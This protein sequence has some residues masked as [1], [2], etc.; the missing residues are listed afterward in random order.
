MTPLQEAIKS[1]GFEW[2]CKIFSLK[3]YVCDEFPELIGVYYS[4]VES[5]LNDFVVRWARGTVLERDTWKLVA[6]SFPRFAAYGKDPLFESKF[7]WSTA[8]CNVK[9]DGS[10][11]MLFWWKDRWIVKNSHAFNAKTQNGTAFSDLFWENYYRFNNLGDLDK[12]LT[13]LF[14]I[15]SL[16][17]KVVRVYPQPKL[18]FLGAFN[19][20]YE[21]TYPQVKTLLNVPMPDTHQFKSCEQVLAMLKIQ[22]VNDPTFEGYVCRDS[23]N[24]RIKFK[25]DS[26]YALHHLFDNG[27]IFLKK[28][29]VK[30]ICNY[31]DKDKILTD[32][33]D[34]RERY[35]EVEGKVYDV[36]NEVFTL[37]AKTRAIK[38]KKEF[39]T[40]V[41][42]SRYAHILFKF[43]DNLAHNQGKSEMN[44]LYSFE[45]NLAG[46]V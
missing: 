17:N 45:K 34:L 9:E 35:E 5:P 36:T 1:N 29:I 41:S 46:W 32:L 12:N 16:D 25:S 33:P 3:T 30:L 28:N 44:I 27:N 40:A 37:W 42:K 26:Y 2:T 10:L 19:G 6:Q 21:L 18:F 15:C 7:D 31:A 43:Y 23:K 20:E 39:A 4:Q 22:A 13:Y 24:R 14:E 11:I 38:N 8:V